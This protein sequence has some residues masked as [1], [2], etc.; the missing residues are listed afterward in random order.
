MRG[1]REK[2]ESTKEDSFLYDD[3]QKYAGWSDVRQGV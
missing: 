2:T 1:N 3:M